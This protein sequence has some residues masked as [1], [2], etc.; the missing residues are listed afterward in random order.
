V[1]INIENN[2]SDKSPLW[3]NPED[4]K[5]IFDLE[6]S[7]QTHWCLLTKWN[8]NQERRGSPIPALS[9]SELKHSAISVIK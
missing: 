3:G 4:A 9:E 8:L 2:I 6:L 1:L 7:D 5:N